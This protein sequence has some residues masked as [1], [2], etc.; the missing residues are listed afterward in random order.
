MSYVAECYTKNKLGR[1]NK[2]VVPSLWDLIHD[3]LR[4]SL[5]NN[6]VHKKYN[7][8]ESSQTTAPDSL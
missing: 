3:D 8:L 1:Q 5:W 7:V 4:C 6:K 2:A